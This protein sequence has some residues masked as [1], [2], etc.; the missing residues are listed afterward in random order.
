MLLSH[1]GLDP[2][3]GSFSTWMHLNGITK[4][5]VS[6]LVKH[7]YSYYLSQR[8]IV[9]TIM[10]VVFIIVIDIDELRKFYYSK[11]YDD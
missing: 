8:G 3:A 11:D 9:K 6:L 7:R 5:S 2:N 10:I 1:T 4:V